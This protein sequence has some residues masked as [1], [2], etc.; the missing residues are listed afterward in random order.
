[1]IPCFA[2]GDKSEKGCREKG[3]VMHSLSDRKGLRRFIGDKAFYRT[4]ALIVVPI[5]IQNTVSNVVNLLDNVMVGQVGTLEMSAVAIINQ[6]MFVFNLCIFGGL[7]GPGIFST[8]YVG[9][10][11]TEGVRACFRLKLWLAVIM[12]TV[13][14]SVFL[15]MP[16]QLIGIYLKESG[17][18]GAAV[19]NS[20]LSYLRVMLFGLLP[21]GITCSYV[22]TLR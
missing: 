3:P 19:M 4:T 6:L 18:D 2:A 15:L 22:M 16:K 13:A 10:G 9:A 5:I 7:A 14:I 17:P 8:Q 12:G 21:F 20:A 1:M 11:D